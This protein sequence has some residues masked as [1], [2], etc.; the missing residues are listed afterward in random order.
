MNLRKKF[1]VKKNCFKEQQTPKLCL[2]PLHTYQMS[3]NMELAQVIIKKHST[4]VHIKKE[5]HIQMNYTNEDNR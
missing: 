5:L 3:K 2:T 1:C 4:V